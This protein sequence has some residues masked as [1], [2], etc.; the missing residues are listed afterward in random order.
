MRRGRH[1]STYT[2]HFQ[3]RQV[4]AYLASVLFPVFNSGGGCAMLR[5]ALKISICPGPEAG[6]DVPLTYAPCAQ[7]KKALHAACG[8]APA[9]AAT[10]AGAGRY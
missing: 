3:T 9:S 8:I 4:A 10:R 7:K 6:L 1:A 2:G 5:M